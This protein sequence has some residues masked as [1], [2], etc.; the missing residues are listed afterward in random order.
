MVVRVL[1]GAISLAACSTQP[2]RGD[3]TVLDATRPPAAGQSSSDR[4][5]KDAELLA[6]LLPA[7]ES[8][9][10]DPA[11]AGPPLERRPLGVKL[12]TGPLVETLQD[13]P[14]VAR[15]LCDVLR[16]PASITMDSQVEPPGRA[17]NPL[18]NRVAY[19]RASLGECVE[20]GLKR[21]RCIRHGV[22]V[23]Y[24]LTSSASPVAL[25]VDGVADDEVLACI[26]RKIHDLR[27]RSLVPPG[28]GPV[29]LL[30]SAAYDPAHYYFMGREI[31]GPVHLAA[32]DPPCGER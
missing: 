24:R 12:T 21:D 22:A 2:R 17:L 1:I 19:A 26:D 32:S 27:L 30:V 18:R 6:A 13:P 23:L 4:T 10:P 31:G 3:T 7:D 14:C 29:D 15:Q 8:V 25:A 9:V 16:A 11:P 28:S 20:A 5:R